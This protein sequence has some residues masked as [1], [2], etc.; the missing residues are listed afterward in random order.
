MNT[1]LSSSKSKI[2]SGIKAFELYDTF[3]F[4]LDLTALIARERGF[5]ID[6]REFDKEMTK[7][8][9]RS[10]AASIAVIDDWQIIADDDEEEFVG[11]DLL[12]TPI[13]IVKYRKVVNKKEGEFFQLVFNMTPFYPESGGQVEIKA[14]WKH[15]MEIFIT[16]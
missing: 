2:I 1:I 8:K 9:E 13:K 15:L 7:Q 5:E 12:S 14:I 11:Y 16:S 3:G 6:Q 4:P 10:R